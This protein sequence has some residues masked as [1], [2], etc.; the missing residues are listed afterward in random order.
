MSKF[1]LVD[2]KWIPIRFLNGNRDELGISDILLRSREIAAIED[3]SPLVV[4]ALHRFL[5]AVLYRALE[6]PTD[7]EQAKALFKAGLPEM[8]ITAYLKRWSDRFW[9]VD[10]AYP[11]LQ[12]PTFKPKKWRSWSA[13][14]VESNADT[15]KVLFDHSNES[16][17]G[18]IT[19][20]AAARWL[21]ATQT[22]AVSTGKSEIAHTGA[23]PSAG[24]MMALPIGNSL[25]D[26]LLFSLVPEN[27]AILE[28]DLPIWEKTQDS[29]EY[30]KT[31]VKIKG[32]EGKEKDRTIERQA[33]GIV[34]LYTWRTRSVII[35]N[36]K[37]ERVTEVGFASGV[38]YLE[39]VPDPMVG[40]VIREVKDEQTKEKV[41]KKF[42]LQ[43]QEKG[44]W[45]DFDS[46]LPD[47]EGLAPKVIEHAATLCRRD[48]SRAPVGIIVLGQK[49][50]P[51][52]PNVAFWRVEYFVLPEAISGDGNL[53]FEVNRI[54]ND[55]ETSG[56]SLKRACEF[57]ARDIIGHGGREVVQ[58]DVSQFVTQ[59]T[60]LPCYWSMLESQF[61]HVLKK[62]T[63]GHDSNV[64][65]CSWLTSVRNALQAA[66][67][68]QATAVST[69]DAWAIRAFVKARKPIRD[70]LSEIDEEIKKLAP[71]KE[72]P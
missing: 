35:R 59:L 6:G 64:V 50:Y 69:G 5:L 38:G 37:H 36:T 31:K 65:R 21:L 52:R 28:N 61:Q 4:A 11:L 54:L 63:L 34:D 68:Q 56:Y 48:H 7:I 44:V 14:A 49:Y 53:R 26:T 32:K 55:A 30:L 47:G 19:F 62:Y 10:D 72:G 45:R 46:L 20:A 71:A 18:S 1:N 13:L 17:P 25:H 16:E 27:K 29:L 51:P 15:A 66:W 9:L 24:S 41:K 2:E 39:S 23:A 3:P 58:E 12:V 60:A 33:T 40:H 22:F 42:A 57:Y 67:N 70:K 8:K 43:F